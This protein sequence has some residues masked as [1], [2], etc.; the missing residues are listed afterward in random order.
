MTFVFSNIV[1]FSQ[2]TIIPMGS[3]WKYLDNGTNQGTTWRDGSYD[4]SGWASGPA[5]LGYTMTGVVTT[6]SYGPSSTNKYI[7]T[8]FRKTVNITQ[9]VIDEAASMKITLNID[10]GAVV[11]VN[12]TE[13]MRSNMPTS[14]ITYTTL[15]NVTVGSS[16]S[17][18]TGTFSSSLLTAGDNTI[19][20]EVHQ[21]AVTSSD[22]YFNLSLAP[23]VPSVSRGPYLQ[24]G[25][26]T[27]MVVRW[28]TDI[29]TDSKVSYGT[30]S[31]NL[32]QSVV[33]S[34]TRT[35]HTV[36][37]TGLNPYTKYYYSVGSTTR[38]MKSGGQYY[39]LTSPLP[40][41]ENKYT[42]WV[43]GDCGN[44]S[45]NQ[46]NVVAKYLQY[47]GTTITN[48]VLLS[49]DNAY[50]SGTEAEFTTNFFNVYQNNIMRNSVF[51]SAPG[52]HDYSNG[53]AAR[54]NDHLVPY[55]DI[56]DL[57][58]N[59]EAGGVPSGTEAF[60]SFDY[61]NIHFLSLDSYGKENNATRLYDTLGA[62]VQWIKQDLA[63][64]DKKWVIAYWHHPPYTMGSHNSDTES[65][66]INIRQNFIRILERLGVDLILT[67][68]SHDYERSKLMK[69][70][71]GNEA[72]FN[73]AIHNL[74]Q[75][76][77][78]YDGSANSCTYLKDT[79][80]NTLQGCVYV[81]SGSA[82]QLGGTQ[83][84]F[85]HNAMYYS[86]ATNGGS[87]VL[88]IEGNR[89]D[90][91]WVCADGVIRDNF[92]MIKDAS[93]VKN[94]A[95][96][97]G[98][99]VTVQAS[100]VGNYGWSHNGATSRSQTLTPTATQTF[101]VTDQYQC[102]ADT[103][104]INVTIPTVTLGAF[105]TTELCAGASINVPFIKTGKFFPGNNFILQLSDATGSFASAINIG[106]LNDTTSGTINGIIP[107]NTPDGGNYRLSI[108]TS[109][110]FIIS[111]SATS[112]F[113][114]N[115]T[116]PSP[117]LTSSDI[118]NTI[119]LGETVDFTASGASL[120]EF[121]IAGI[122]QGAASAQSIFS[123]AALTN[124][125]TVEVKGYNACGS[126]F[127]QAI[128][129][130]V[131]STP[132]VG[133]TT[134]APSNTI[135]TGEALQINASGADTY[136][137]FVDNVSQG[138]ASAV[139]TFTSSSFTNGQEVK[140]VGNNVCFTNDNAIIVIVNTAAPVIITSNDADNSICLGNN[141]QFTSTG[142]NVQW[143]SDAALTNQIAAGNS[144][145]TTPAS[146]TTYNYYVIQT[147]ANNC[148][149]A[150]VQ[151]SLVVNPLPFAPLTS[152][153]SVCRFQSNPALT[154]VGTNII[155]YSN[156][157]LTTQVAIGNSFTPSNTLPGN[158]N[159]YATQTDANGCVSASSVAML[160]INPLPAIPNAVSQVVCDYDAIPALTATGTNIQWYSNPSLTTHVASGN[161]FNTGNTAPGVYSYYL[162]QTDANGC[163]SASNMVSLVIN[164]TPTAPV[165][166]GNTS[167]CAGDMFASLNASGTNVLWYNSP[168]LTTVM[169]SGN[170]FAPAAAGT[171]YATQTVSGC[172][173]SSSSVIVVVNTL[174]S[175]A[176][177]GLN[178][179]YFITDAP[180]VISGTP[181][182]GSFS[183][184]GVVGNTFDPALAG[185]GGPYTITYSF[186]DVNGCSNSSTT[187]VT[188]T[189]LTSVTSLNNG[190]E[191]VVYP[192][193]A[194]DYTVVNLNIS[195]EETA[196]VIL[197]DMLGK[198]I[199]ISPEK[200]LAQG[201]YSIEI[202][203]NNLNLSNGV[204]WLKIKVGNEEK[205]IK[206]I[207]Q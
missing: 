177:S 167:Y 85:P 32:S 60:Y 172:T 103:F 115:E 106:I 14:A 36:Q 82:G 196:S 183:G 204:Y 6:V 9:A 165:I 164:A 124:A 99:S 193:P 26:P 67:G 168:A 202:N 121:F 117:A 19:A 161:I 79:L 54:Q 90:A 72:S 42:F 191:I 46:A 136:E 56:F 55:Y 20:V 39:F 98:E 53:S 95:I 31:L 88:E 80:H 181:V 27:S 83:A 111:S 61:G 63:A 114:V 57:P 96:N 18:F 159:Y 128:A 30:D 93:K 179:N 197:Y 15:A 45:T 24:I 160:T 154:A 127:S 144:Y 13:V 16:P 118:D 48:G 134:S 152:N 25:T 138:A 199:V 137:F 175:V 186:T 77:G 91:K 147:D 104:K 201:Q 194:N 148:T 76:T 142:T 174:P 129:T 7:T 52:N 59:G 5:P 139:S 130:T 105:S 149:S 180:V 17:A 162:T 184:Q 135:C 87:L 195:K 206:V 28:L 29:A 200:E 108:I 153:Q 8:Y 23:L 188:V 70:Y 43:N 141:I 207:F 185:V 182:G 125:Q 131:I 62:Q 21:A 65:E 71:Y 110:P 89:L 100:W 22:I 109:I 116:I 51:W 40:Y 69:G 170:N 187:D 102:V 34:G 189:L 163:T 155:W 37:L 75:S 74:S 119:C 143:F 101:V 38:T 113:V 166:S 176:I 94:F 171:Y 12:G 44:N 140:V 198:S 73:A 203:K 2:T 173:S 157:T 120:Y 146:A 122:S 50:T 156:T 126:D 169:V 192:N 10:D 123:T 33:V 1:A 11:Y 151:T 92:T 49:G 68:H 86:N 205:H 78:K 4:D 190:T 58:T 35:N 178:A 133:I 84:A 158:Y 64:N 145:I 3:V 150:P 81:V 132:V 41:T 107:T 47:V 112:G 97:L 66:L